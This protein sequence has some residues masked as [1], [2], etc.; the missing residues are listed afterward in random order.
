MT[1]KY[2]TGIRFNHTFGVLEVWS[3]IG[4]G[5]GAVL[6]LVGFLTQR[7][8]LEGLGFAFL[9]LAVLVLRAHLGQP[10]RGWRAVTKVATA[11]VSRGT[12]FIALFTAFS[13]ASLL[14]AY[15][16]G[17]ANVRSALTWIAVVL[18]FPVILYAGMMLRSMRA[19][20][21]WRGPLLPV[22]FAAHSAATG[23][24]IAYAI[25]AASG[26]GHAAWLRPAAI[27]AIILAALLLAAH[28]L[29]VER[30]AGTQASRERL[31]AGDLGS[32]FRLGAIGFGLIVPLVALAAVPIA[33][34]APAALAIVAAIARF[35]GDYAYR[36]SIV[37][38]GAYEPI[39]PSHVEYYARGSF[40]PTSGAA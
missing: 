30:S 40:K 20:R 21:L 8:P 16:D 2:N 38:A 19:I 7:L 34:V 28:L 25:A 32:R 6:Y 15:V 9:I 23:L 1:S 12:V 37:T 33:G 14:A 35:Y 26:A 18:A 13:G 5:V 11:W 29:A 4:E 17:P 22:S 10:M 39:F 27:I 3:F 24:T 36:F 31:L